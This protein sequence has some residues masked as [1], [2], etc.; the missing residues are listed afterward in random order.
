M[1]IGFPLI[2]STSALLTAGIIYLFPNP[3]HS[4][5]KDTPPKAELELSIQEQRGLALVTSYCSDCH[6]VGATGEGKHPTAPKFRELHLRYDVSLLDEALVEGLVAHPDMPEF[7][8]DVPQ[9]NAIIS[10]LKTFETQ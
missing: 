9:A 5:P 4:P 1:R 7:E 3:S 2:I 6:A 10:Y 8:F